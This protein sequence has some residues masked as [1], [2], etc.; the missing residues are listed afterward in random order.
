MSN[1]EAFAGTKLIYDC[2]R[3]TR[4]ARPVDIL[5]GGDALPRQLRQRTSTIPPFPRLRYTDEWGW[6]RRQMNG[7][8]LCNREPRSGD[9]HSSQTL[10]LL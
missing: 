9:G 6:R 3:G 1:Q 5:I 2:T 8:V 7:T 10:L 4:P